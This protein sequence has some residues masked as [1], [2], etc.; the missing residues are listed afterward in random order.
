MQ[1]GQHQL[2]QPRAEEKAPVLAGV[3]KDKGFPG[4][5]TPTWAPAGAESPGPV[6]VAKKVDNLFS[7]KMRILSE[8]VILYMNHMPH[9]HMV[10]QMHR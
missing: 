10:L 5:P 3:V 4:R 9:W 8:N 7:L 2:G 6:G 1:G